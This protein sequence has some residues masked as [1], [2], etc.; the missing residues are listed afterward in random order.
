MRV[1]LT[2][3]AYEQYVNHTQETA[4][5]VEAERRFQEE[6]DLGAVMYVKLQGRSAVFLNDAYWLYSAEGDVVILE[7]ALAFIQRVTRLERIHG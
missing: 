6:M 7:K 2:M 3:E 1:R 4:G 5:W